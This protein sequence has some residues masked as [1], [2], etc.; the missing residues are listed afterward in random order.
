MPTSV[1]DNGK[2]GQQQ[3]TGSLVVTSQ[4][5]G[6]NCDVHAPGTGSQDHRKG[7]CGEG[8]V[9]PLSEDGAEGSARARA[10]FGGQNGTGLGQA[11]LS[12]GMCQKTWS[13]CVKN[14]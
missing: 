7:R 6:Q 4:W 14:M 9:G 3:D 12:R 13:W 11:Q 2:L 8:R 5:A 10:S 1:S